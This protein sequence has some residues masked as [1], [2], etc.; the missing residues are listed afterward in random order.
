MP[1]QV[2]RRIAIRHEEIEMAMVYNTKGTTYP[3]FR[4]GKGGAKI[5]GDNLLSP[6]NAASG[7]FWF[8]Q[9][10][11]AIKV[12]SD[13]LNEWKN[14]AFDDLVIGGNTIYSVSRSSSITI[15]DGIIINPGKGTASINGDRILT[16]ADSI[17]ATTVGG[18]SAN[19]IL[20]N[21]TSGNINGSLTVGGDL[22]VTGVMNVIQRDVSTGESVCVLNATWPDDTPPT[23]QSGLFVY[24]GNTDFTTGLIWDEATAQWIINN[25]T[26]VNPK[27]PNFPTSGAGQTISD[28]VLWH[29]GNFKPSDKLDQSAPAVDSNKFGGNL[30]GYYLNAANINAGTI[31][32]SRLPSFIDYVG[33]AVIQQGTGA[34]QTSDSVQI[35]WSPEMKLKASVN[36]NDIGAL[37]TESW[38][39]NKY[40]I[41]SA[42]DI[43]HGKILTTG[44]GGLNGSNTIPN[45]AATPN[46]YYNHGMLC[47]LADAQVLGIP[48]AT[49]SCTCTLVINAHNG[50]MGA[51][52][53]AFYGQEVYF[54][55]SLDSQTWSPW[56]RN[57][58]S[59]SGQFS[60]KLTVS[61][62]PVLTSSVQVIDNMNS[63]DKM[64]AYYSMADLSG[65]H[66]VVGFQGDGKL[67]LSSPLNTFISGAGTK[68]ELQSDGAVFSTLSNA[69]KIDF[70]NQTSFMGGLSF[71]TTGVTIKGRSGN[72]LVS[73]DSN[74]SI[75]LGTSG[76]IYI[77]SPG[78]KVGV[79]T[80]EPA[81]KLDIDQ[82]SS[83]QW[84]QVRTANTSASGAGDIGSSAGFEAIGARGDNNGTYYGRIGLAFRKTNGSFINMGTNVGSVL[85]GGQWGTD[86]TFQSPKVAYAASI[87]G[88]ADGLWNSNIDMP[89]GI[90]FYT[91]VSGDDIRAA[92]VTYGTLRMR[93]SSN[94]NLLLGTTVDQGSKLNVVGNI[95]STTF[96]GSGTNIVDLNALNISSGT[97]SDSR[98]PV[99]M[100]GKIFTTDVSAPSFNTVSARKYKSDISSLTY[101]ELSKI[102]QLEPVSYVYTPSGKKDIGLIA[103]DVIKLIPSVVQTLP[104]GE[105]N[106]LDYG[107]LVTYLI[108]IVKD[109]ENRIT[110]L[111]EALVSQLK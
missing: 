96:S 65:D 102:L 10:T 100:T 93:L 14:L 94:G 88:F 3:S 85:F 51:T 34:G 55:H 11:G 5:H 106:A 31:P 36:N 111:E 97:I 42:N 7:D 72:A 99:T 30:P 76:Q 73:L 71:N 59:D 68:L 86:Q 49:D 35:G 29:S 87:K 2:A 109:Q 46:D 67:R 60:G 79:G 54:R 15:G 28:Y 18:I 66:G 47:G 61:S 4:I 75:S 90:D 20:R 8:D 62:T 16:A 98:L 74:D 1:S 105:P 110:K 57:A 23:E 108:G 17:D 38:V 32:V 39:S 12:K 44:A 52:Q 53:M 45:S 48:G 22:T 70:S 63:S 37:A 33:H 82:K 81:Y 58:F 69:M 89:T 6:E 56:R 95:N 26:G 43:T 41:A 103:D 77:D 25:R 104:T 91:G 83:D 92:N 64:T 40:Q 19:K 101:G 78:G 24:R 9:S 107:K 27:D 21:D 50:Y 84:V 80:T 13:T